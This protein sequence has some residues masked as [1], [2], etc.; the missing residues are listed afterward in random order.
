MKLK[1]NIGAGKKRS[2][3]YRCIHTTRGEKMSVACLREVN[4]V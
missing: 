2:R 4:A 3:Y 1:Q